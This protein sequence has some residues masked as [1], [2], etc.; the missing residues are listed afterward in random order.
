MCCQAKEMWCAVEQKKK[1]LKLLLYSI[2]ISLH[3][4]IVHLLGVRK[5]IRYPI[6]YIFFV[7]RFFFHLT[8]SGW[9]K[10]NFLNPWWSRQVRM[11]IKF[12]IYSIFFTSFLKCRMRWKKKSMTWEIFCWIRFMFTFRCRR[13]FFFVSF[14]FM[15]FSKNCIFKVRST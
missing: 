8:D 15:S 1:T 11:I 5:N 14:P 6:K 12:N 10:K 7:W 4:E 3:T 2:F 13:T 9:M